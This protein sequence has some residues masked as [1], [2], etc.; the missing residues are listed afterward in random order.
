[1]TRNRF[2]DSYKIKYHKLETDGEFIF[3]Q[4]YCKTMFQH[5]ISVFYYRVQ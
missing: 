1:M 5:K 4:F 2:T 3:Q